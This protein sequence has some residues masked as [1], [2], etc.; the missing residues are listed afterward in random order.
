MSKSGERRFVQSPDD[1]ELIPG[2][3]ETLQRYRDDGW[4]MAIAS[5]QGGV[6][7]GF[8][9]LECAI[10]ETR[11]AMKLCKIK[12]A[13]IA[14]SFESNGLGLAYHILPK[15]LRRSVFEIKDLRER[16]RKPAPGMLLYLFPEISERL[17][18]GD[19]PEDKEAAV[20]AG[21]LFMDAVEWRCSSPSLA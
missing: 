9:T 17:Y 4:V 12:N 5:N 18:V 16:F 6:A 10:A 8:K 11:Y 14:P 15:S 7:A 20:N 19:R 21:I 13:L 2:A 1:Q 3:A